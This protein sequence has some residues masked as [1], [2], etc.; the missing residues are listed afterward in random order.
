MMPC[1]FIVM[2]VYFL[3]FGNISDVV[4]SLDDFSRGHL[5]FFLFFFMLSSGAVCLGKA[6]KKIDLLSFLLL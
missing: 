3:F 1:D 2:V 6:G 4:L 5:P